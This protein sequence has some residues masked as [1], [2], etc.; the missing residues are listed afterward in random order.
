VWKAQEICRTEEPQLLQI[1]TGPDSGHRV[2]CHFPVEVKGAGD[3]QDSP[4]GR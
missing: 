3:V 1:G 4:A 2:A